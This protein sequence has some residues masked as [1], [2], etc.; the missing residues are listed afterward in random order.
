MT[1]TLWLIATFAAPFV[2]AGIANWRLPYNEGQLPDVLLGLPG[3][4]ALLV[5]AL[6]RVFAPASVLTV[7]GLVCAAMVSVVVV[8]IG[9]DVAA[10]PTSHNL[11]PFE[12]LIAA[13]I[14]FAEGLIGALAGSA[15]SFVSRKFAG[16]AR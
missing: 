14:G 4:F 5:A 3:L 8:R 12:I 1:R 9:V 2:V 16:D 6:C 7:A 10:D 11:L 13:V 15:I